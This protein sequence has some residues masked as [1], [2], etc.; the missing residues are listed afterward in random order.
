MR[1]GRFIVF[2]AAIGAPLLHGQAKKA[3]NPATEW[4]LY[5]HDLAG[6]RYS[7][8]AQINVKNVAKL[9]QAWTYK[10]PRHPN[11]GGITGGYELT[12]IVVKGVMYLTAVDSVV[13]LEPETGR[14]LWRYSVATGQV[15]RRGVSYWAGDQNNPPRII[16]TSGRRMV[17]L[18]A[19]TGKLDCAVSSE[20]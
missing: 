7:P 2:V 9:S 13:A 11:S 14:E 8:L 16:F 18:N 3:Q 12:P 17:G 4:P 20:I 10:L 6:S 5:T 19:N 15:S 1:I